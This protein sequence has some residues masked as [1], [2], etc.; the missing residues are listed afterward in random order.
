MIKFF[1]NLFE[2][3]LNN[4]SSLELYVQSKSP[5]NICDVEK[6]TKEYYTKV[7]QGYFAG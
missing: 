7:S 3:R 1:Q 6:Y 5:Q 2:M 4:Q